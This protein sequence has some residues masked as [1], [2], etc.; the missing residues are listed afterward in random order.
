M[1]LQDDDED[2]TGMRALLRSLPDPGPM[3]DDLVHRIQSALTELPA[4]D[5]PGEGHADGGRDED[6]SR[7]T[8]ASRS[9]WWGRHAGRAAV[10]AVVLLGGGAVASGSLGI[11]GGGGDST[12]AAGS[13]A[14]GGSQTESLSGSRGDAGAPRDS[15][16]GQG[17]STQEAA[18]GPVLVRHS[19]RSYTAGD[20]PEQVA[21]VATGTT[22]PPLTAE[23]PAIGP[24]GTEVGV[25]SCLAALGLPR[26]S[27]AD[28]DL[29]SLDG[30]PA[31]VLVITLGGERTAYAVGRDC[32]TGNPSL[33]AGPVTVP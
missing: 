17:A 16:S 3:P 13:S 26:A 10:A 9:S 11:L 28:V 31:A 21:G 23:S 7:G 30:T 29:A 2:P 24:I 20:L 4:L 32:T 6:V 8:P 27:A 33:L 22:T 15:S 1:T 19:G 18:L 5:G 25:R 12:S 14:E